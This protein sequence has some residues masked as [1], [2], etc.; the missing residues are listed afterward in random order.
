MKK[1]LVIIMAMTVIMLAAC[2]NLKEKNNEESSNKSKLN[3]KIVYDLPQKYN[4]SFGKVNF[5]TDIIIDNRGAN[6]PY[7]ESTAELQKVN[8][9]KAV[10]FF[11]SGKKEK[12]KHES[13]C[14]N[15]KNEKVKAI[16]YI[17]ENGEQLSLGPNSS[18]ITF[19]SKSLYPYIIKSFRLQNKDERY[20]ADKYSLKD[21]L[22]FSTREKAFEDIKNT[23][24]EIGIQIDDEY[25]AYALD[26]KIMK[27]EQY[28]MGADGNEDKSHYKNSWSEEDDAYYFIIGQKYKGLPTYH[29]FSE[30]FNYKGD[31]NE[32]I[33]VVYSK[34]GIEYISIEKVFDFKENSKDIKIVEF[35]NIANT[36]VNKYEQILGASS[37]N[38]KSAKLH[39]MIDVLSGKG[40]YNVKPVWILDIE[41]S[42][43]N[44]GAIGN[45]QM[46]IDAVTGE[47]IV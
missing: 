36:V 18:M 30:F 45:I 8:Y 40:V 13:D 12:E 29:V 34:N 33:Q 5:E 24:S 42:T 27:L 6:K 28:S 10:K 32:P 1:V 37:Y 21:E 11:L 20:N 25:K 3:S 4:G 2:E 41:E 46:I 31:E 7:V 9:E 26:H 35:K 38:V 16:T 47:E 43:P 39:Y 23:L 14:Q 44:D 17:G 22:N 19:L 15:E